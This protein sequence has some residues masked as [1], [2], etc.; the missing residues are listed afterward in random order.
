MFARLV[1]RRKQNENASHE[2]A[3]RFAKVHSRRESGQ[4]ANRAVNVGSHCVRNSDAT[5]DR[6]RAEFLALEQSRQQ[7]GLAITWKCTDG[8][9]PVEDD[10]ERLSHCVDGT[11]FDRELMEAVEM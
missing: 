8:D 11:V 10:R 5:A 4:S 9:E 2:L 3:I 1:E 7:V 6:R